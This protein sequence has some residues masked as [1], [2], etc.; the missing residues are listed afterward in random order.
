[1]IGASTTP[2]PTT[3]A[4]DDHDDHD[5]DH[6]DG[7]EV[8]AVSSCHLDGGDLSVLAISLGIVPVLTCS[9]FLHVG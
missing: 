2:A 1:M 8:T 7:D 4:A 5:H 3:T 9:Q 6:A